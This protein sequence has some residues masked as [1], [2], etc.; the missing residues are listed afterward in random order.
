MTKQIKYP[1]GKK[2]NF[3]TLL[4]IFGLGALLAGESYFGFQLHKLSSQQQQIKQDYSLVNSI[5]F[6]VFSVDEWREKISD[7]VGQQVNDF[8]MTA[9]QKKDL[10][11]Q[12]E[13]Q[14][15]GLVDKTVKEV[16]K[17][18]KSL[19]GKLK[20]LAFNSFVD[21]DE[22]H[23]LV[24]SFAKTIITRINSPASQKRLKGIASSKINQLEQQ[25][26]DNTE[27][28][29]HEVI[30]HMFSKYHVSSATGFDRSIKANLAVM[31]RLTYHYAYGMLICVLLAIVLWLFLR[32][33]VHLHRILFV[34][35][36]LFAVVLLGSAVTTTIIEVDARLQTLKFEL[37]GEHIAFNNQVLFF[38]S[39]SILGIVETL[40]DQPKPDAVLVGALIMIFVIVLPI[41]RLL[42]KGIHV[43]GKGRFAD[44]KPVRYLAFESGKWDMSDV[45]V[46]GVGMTYIGLNGILKSQLSGLNIATGPLRTVTENNSSLQP[47]FILFTA[48]VA[49]AMV[50]SYILKRIIEP[51]EKKPD[52]LDEENIP[53]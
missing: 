12:V 16:N 13:R 3:P 49:F 24:P 43:W 5:T 51:D 50:L 25:T 52:V 15:N 30:R 47:G 42:A 7:V 22:I 11:K 40:I 37:L 19:A 35:S 27:S 34:I 48:Y 29:Q 8:R 2:V 32:S 18:Q 6:G 53:A 39:K 33:Q 20:K 23:Q 44:N 4:L 9:S 21:A 36:L 31:H 28:V 45:M 14:L 46:V 17:P 10:Q 1:K 26:Y 41:L 38:Q